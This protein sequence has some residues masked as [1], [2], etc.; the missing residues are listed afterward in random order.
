M[1]GEDWLDRG[2]RR[3]EHDKRSQRRRKS[4]RQ[5]G[6]IIRG[7]ILVPGTAAGK[8]QYKA[9]AGKTEPLERLRGFSQV[10]RKHV[11]MFVWMSVWRRLAL[12]YLVEIGGGHVTGTGGTK[13]V[14]AYG[15][16]RGGLRERVLKARVLGSEERIYVREGAE[17]FRGFGKLS[18]LGEERADLAPVN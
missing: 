2:F 13:S 9:R 1:R 12:A 18:V 5:R 17:K 15:R 7:P 8:E 16:G 10:A 4:A 14:E 11:E 6:E 3:A